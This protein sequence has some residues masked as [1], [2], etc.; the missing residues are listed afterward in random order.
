MRS[1]IIISLILILTSGIAFAEE[2][3]S[4][5]APTGSVITSTGTD[6]TGVQKKEATNSGATSTGKDSPGGA[7]Q[8]CTYYS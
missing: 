8:Y 6:S 4:Q 2:G 1:L 5:K 7:I 3:Q